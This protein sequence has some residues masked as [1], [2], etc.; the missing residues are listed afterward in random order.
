MYAGQIV[1]TRA[2]R[3]CSTATRCIPTRPSLAA[4]APDDRRRP[5]AGW[6]RSRAGRCRRSRRPT[7]ARSRRAAPSPRTRCRAARPPLRALDGGRCAA[8]APSELR[9]R[10]PGGR[11][12]TCLRP[13]SRPPGCARSTASVV[14]VDDVDLDGRRRAARW[15][16]SASPARARRRSRGCSS[17]SPRRPPGRSPPAGAT[18]R[19]PARSAAE[20]RRRGARGPDRLPGPLL[21]PRPAPQRRAGARRGAAPAPPAASKAER[22]ARV[23]RAGRPRRPRRAPARAR[24]RA[25][26]RGGQRQRVAIARALAAE[27][28]V[29]IL[30]ESVAALDVSIQAQI[31][32]LLAD[33]REQTGVSYVLI[34]HD[35]AVVRQITDEA[36]VMHRGRVVERG[37]TARGPRRTRRTT[38]TQLLRASVPRP[39][40]EADARRARPDTKESPHDLLTS[41]SSTA[42]SARSTR[43]RP[44]ADRARRRRRRDRR[45]RRRRGDPRAARRRDRGHRP[46]TAPRSCRADR[47]PH[48]PVHRRARRARRRPARRAHARRRARARRRGAGALRASASGCSAGASTTTS[49][50]DAGISGDADRRGASAARRRC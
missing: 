34:S 42:A 5:R 3:A 20:R 36:I 18:A 17:A 45:G 31:L 10:L 41:P 24:C 48:A 12:A 28:R 9:G 2:S 7:A 32:N 30:D 38:Y 6:R 26:C 35:L 14:A 1:E 39:G 25:R 23:A 44:A 43:T 40:L 46:R 8:S 49:F 37:P 13:C 15:R 29:I 16:S 33:I 21:E 22:A 50:A 11:S 19:P 27:P 47:Q 4:R